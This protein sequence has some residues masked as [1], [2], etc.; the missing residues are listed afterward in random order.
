MMA[1]IN[2]M[3]HPVGSGPIEPVER[4]NPAKPEGRRA[5]LL[6]TTISVARTKIKLIIARRTGEAMILWAFRIIRRAKFDDGDAET[7][8]ATIWHG[9][10]WRGQPRLGGVDTGV[11]APMTASRA[12]VSPISGLLTEFWQN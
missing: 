10:F 6:G 11:A 2:L 12:P 8:A 7:W 4:L 9:G 5:R 1:M 3:E